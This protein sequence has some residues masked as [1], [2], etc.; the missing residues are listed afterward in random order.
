MVRKLFLM[1]LL[2]FL[3]AGKNQAGEP[4]AWDLPQLMEHMA[5]VPSSTASFTEKKY[6]AVLTA[7]L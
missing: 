2:A 1:L 6:L 4:T 5:Q 3:F 7:P